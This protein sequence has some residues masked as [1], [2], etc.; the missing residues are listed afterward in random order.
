MVFSINPTAAKTQAMFQQMAIAQNGTGAASPITGGTSAPAPPPAASTSSAAA[1]P[2]AAA[3]PPAASS[4]TIATGS[5]SVGADGSC[6]CTCQC[7]PGSFP[8][9]AAQ[10]VGAHGGWGG[11]SNP[12]IPS[13]AI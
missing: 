13:I 10:G 5:G 9:N 4:G 11:K 8:V 6:A 3:P 12:N 1:P 2:A 7:A